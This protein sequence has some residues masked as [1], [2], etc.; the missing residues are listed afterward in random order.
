MKRT[1]QPEAVLESV[2]DIE[3]HLSGE[4]KMVRSKLSGLTA[5]DKRLLFLSSLEDWY[6][7]ALEKGSDLGEK[8]AHDLASRL[9]RRARAN[10]PQREVN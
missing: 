1:T 5:E 10:D 3:E 2:M 9:R 6:A 8:E 4:A 7:D